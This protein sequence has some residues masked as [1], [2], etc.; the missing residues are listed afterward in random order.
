VLNLAGPAGVIMAFVFAVLMAMAVWS[1]LYSA[2]SASGAACLPVTRTA[3]FLSAVL[4]GFVPMACVNL[5]VFLLSAAAE[6]W[7]GVVHLPSLLTWLCV[8]LM[9]LLFFYGFATFC[10]MLTGNI[11]VLPAVYAVLNFV[12]AG[13][14]I[15]LDTIASFF[16]YGL[17]GLETG[18]L[19]FLSPVIPLAEGLGA[20]VEYAESLAGEL[21][22]S[23]VGFDGW[24]MAA[25]YA[26]IGVLLHFGAWALLRR[27]KMETAGDV[28]A[29]QALKPV[30]RWCMGIGAGLLFASMMLVLFGVSGSGQMTVLV[31]TSAY[32]VIGA[33]LGWFIAEMLIRR[34]FRV[35]RGGWSGWGGCAL[36]CVILLAGLAAV[37]TDLFGAERRRPQPESVDSVYVYANGESVTFSSPEGIA[38]VADLHGDIIEHKPLQDQCARQDYYDL[39]APYD[40][41]DYQAVNVGIVYHLKNGNYFHRGYRLPHLSGAVDDAAALQMLF[42]TKEAIS[43]RKETL[44]PYTAENVRFGTATAVMTAAECAK[45][46]GYDDPAD[47]VLEE[48]AG[49]TPKAA[50]AL[51]S[52]F[53]E[54]LLREALENAVVTP[55]QYSYS[56][57]S[58]AGKEDMPTGVVNV[59]PETE[60]GFDWERIWLNY[61]LELNAGDAWQ[62][63]STCIQPDIAEGSL[64]RVWIMTNEG[65]GEGAY[66]GSITIAAE[67]PQEGGREPGL[68]RDRA[69]PSEY[70]WTEPTDYS[71][72]DYDSLTTTPTPDA[73]RTG[74]YLAERG[75]MLHTPAEIWGSGS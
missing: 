30:F 13:A 45:A 46:A 4:G 36:C 41:E 35:F 50:E 29:V 67:S 19:K 15:L 18:I 31:L 2:R 28:V 37:E 10:A 69:A 14:V 58:S 71:Q 63:Y 24:W 55:W 21:I 32:L 75:I 66:A 70:R 34:S 42:N 72:G 64:G 40:G 57:Y 49:Y 23:S 43:S 59:L 1:F 12:A 33:V 60:E 47:Y 39:K 74:A 65:Y 38:A 3:Q 7:I 20:T 17:D 62:L 8:T 11:I 44:F 9:T 48:L 53:R 52:A 27:R 56:S 22:P 26:V 73:V 54:K 61:T 6:L 5:L 16:L 51:D 25:A 68:V